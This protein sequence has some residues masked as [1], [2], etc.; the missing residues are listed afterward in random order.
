M[1]FY[2]ARVSKNVRV[3]VSTCPQ[4]CHPGEYYLP[5]GPPT[6]NPPAATGDR[7]S[8]CAAALMGQLP[9]TENCYSDCNT[10]PVPCYG[11][12][13][14]V[15]T[16][17]PWVYPG[18]RNLSQAPD[19]NNCNDLI[20]QTVADGSIQVAAVP[21]TLQ[22][23][24]HIMAGYAG[25]GEY[26]YAR[27]DSDTKTWSSKNGIS[28][29]SRYDD[30]NNLITDPT[31]AAFSLNGQKLDF[32]GYFITGPPLVC[33]SPGSPNGGGCVAGEPQFTAGSP[34]PGCGMPGF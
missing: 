9:A 24:T 12:A 15:V 34:W 29:P 10:F 7:D 11:Y 14:N 33:P 8:Y 16:A 32:C 31:K 5:P 6:W 26:H 2:R 13:M 18:M 19:V 22:P 21:T 20:K 28:M 3:G 17:K 23:G 30:N 4:T 25:G 27:L 1:S